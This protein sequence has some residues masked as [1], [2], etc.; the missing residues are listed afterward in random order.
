LK[1]STFFLTKKIASKELGYQNILNKEKQN[2]IKEG[3]YTKT[4]SM[5]NKSKVGHT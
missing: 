2:K 3:D 5:M 1:I 4:S